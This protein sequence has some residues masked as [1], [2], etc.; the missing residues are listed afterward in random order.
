[1]IVFAHIFLLP[2]VA[3]YLTLFLNGVGWLPSFPRLMT[4]EQLGAALTRAAEVGR[5]RFGTIGDISCD[6]EVQDSSTAGC[7][8]NNLCRLNRAVLSSCLVH[9]P[10]QTLSSSTD[11][12]P[13]LLIFQ[14]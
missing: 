13:Y 6:V 9:Q 14:A 7:Y 1:M 2:Q 12:P 10:F 5:A 8:C 4:N 3:P 11:H